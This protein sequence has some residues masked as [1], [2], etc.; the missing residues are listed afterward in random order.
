[1]NAK[2][3]G[4][5]YSVVVAN[6]FQQHPWYICFIAKKNGSLPKDLSASLN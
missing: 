6:G 5:D 4:P 3:L 2:V 1:M